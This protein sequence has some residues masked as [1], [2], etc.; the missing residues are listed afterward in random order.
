MIAAGPLVLI[1]VHYVLHVGKRH[2]GGCGA[3]DRPRRLV[4]LVPVERERHDRV[5][6]VVRAGQRQRRR[7][8]RRGDGR[9]VAVGAHE[10]R[11]RVGHGGVGLSDRRTVSVLRIAAVRATDRPGVGGRPRRGGRRRV[12]LF[13]R[14][15]AEQRFESGA[16]RLAPLRRLLLQLQ[17]HL[18]LFNAHR[19][20]AGDGTPPEYRTH[21]GV[22]RYT[23]SET[24]ENKTRALEL[25]YWSI[26]TIAR[27]NAR[28]RRDRTGT[29]DA[30]NRVLRRA[31]G[32]V[33]SGVIIFVLFKGIN[34]IL[35]QTRAMIS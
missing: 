9:P 35:C 10:P 21:F 19:T 20:A 4:V 22:Y 34:T 15:L 27:R 29:E 30:S 5:P 3:R 17:S 1:G 23:G 6:V 18:L 2:G 14:R 11:R 31:K 25:V 12:L 8:W 13:G 28:E 26:C 24:F 32:A 33:A 16:R 7:G